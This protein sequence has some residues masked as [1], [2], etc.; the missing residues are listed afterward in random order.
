MEAGERSMTTDYLLRF[1]DL[2]PT[3]NWQI[4]DQIEE[5]LVIRAIRPI[6]AVVPENRDPLLMVDDPRDDFWDRAREWQ[7]RGWTIG[8]HGYQH[9]NLTRERGVVGLNARSEFAGLSE[10]SQRER[11]SAGLSIMN[12]HRLEPQVWVAPNHSFDEHTVTTLRD[13]GLRVIS[14]GLWMRPFRDRMQVTWVPHQI[15]RFRRMP[16]GT[17]TVGIHHNGWTSELLGNFI[18]DLDA[19]GERIRDLPSV[20]ESFAARR[21]SIGDEV[22][23]RTMLALIRGKRFA[24]GIGVLKVPADAY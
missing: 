24:R 2:C 21:K 23:S 11:L 20:V 17:W 13:L 9:V 5:A 18:R 15:W 6:L 7:A 4:W 14:D 12:R 10:A 8:M 1:D 16:P 19:Y 3:M 22:A